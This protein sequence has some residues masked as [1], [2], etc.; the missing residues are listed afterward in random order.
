[1]RQFRTNLQTKLLLTTL[2]FLLLLGVAV[3]MLV[4]RGFKATQQNAAEQSVARLNA[5]GRN[6]LRTLVDREGQI[7]FNYIQQP[8]RATRLAAEYLGPSKRT[9][10]VKALLLLPSL[11]ILMGICLIAAGRQPVQRDHSV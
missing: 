10:I 11:S 1:M 5:Q 4:T 2:S 6:A 9:G 8:A 7:T 3:G